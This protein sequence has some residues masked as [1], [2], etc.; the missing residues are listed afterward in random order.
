MATGLTS[1]DAP[2]PGDVTVCLYCVSVLEFGE[3]MTLK[4]PSQERKMRL[5]ERSPELRDAVTALMRKRGM[6]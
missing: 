4:A 1:D 2:R 6:A 5:L 3:G